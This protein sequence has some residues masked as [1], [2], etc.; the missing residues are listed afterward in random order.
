[1][2]PRGAT[3]EA[4]SRGRRGLCSCGTLRR[5]RFQPSRPPCTQLTHQVPNE[6]AERSM[7]SIDEEEP[8]PLTFTSA[9]VSPRPASWAWRRSCRSAL[10]T[11]I[12]PRRAAAG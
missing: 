6:H 12:G 1:M 11:Y 5:L 2:E 4:G 7:Q 9:I 3:P 8:R 10:A